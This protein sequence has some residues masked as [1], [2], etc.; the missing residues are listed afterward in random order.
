MATSTAVLASLAMVLFVSWH[1]LVSL[2]MYGS[3]QQSDVT[4]WMSLALVPIIAYYFSNAL[5]TALRRSRTVL[6]L[7][8]TNSVL[9]ALLSVGF[10]YGWRADAGR[11]VLAYALAA[12]T[13]A[14][15]SA[16]GVC[17]IWN[18]LPDD[19]EPLAH[20][21][22]WTQV[23]PFALAVW[24]T[25]WLANAFEL[26]DRYLIVHA[27]G[28]GASEA[29]TLLGNYHSSRVLPLLLVSVT[30]TLATILLPYLSHD[31]ERGRREAVVQQLN[32]ACKILCFLL[33]LA[34][35]AILAVAPW[36]F[37]SVLRGKYA[38]G[39]AV[40][41]CTLLYCIWFGLARAAQ[42]YLWCAHRVLLASL[43]WGGGLAVNVTLNVVLLPRYGLPGVVWATSAGNVTALALIC[44]FS[45]HAGM[46]FSRGF[47]MAAV[48]P[49]V[50]IFPLAMA[51]AAYA[52]FLEWSELRLPGG[53]RA[54]LNRP[55]AGTPHHDCSAATSDPGW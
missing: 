51:F 36:L 25:N 31:W 16:R 41:P 30:S 54:G 48:L 5:L 15:F 33:T 4:G 12:A 19:G 45:R 13:A 8:F 10:V 43:A 6:R 18:S 27:S 21:A 37:A 7:E 46:R 17:R 26:A 22:L 3:T 39:L 49:F 32:F 11:V 34:A 50:C 44:L 53:D 42:K 35:L 47:V 55:G 38:S 2:L 28:L 29:L 23:L 40:L 9:F 1:E 52:V 14:V 20:R 24:G